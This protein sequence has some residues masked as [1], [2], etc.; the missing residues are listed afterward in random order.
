[1]FNFIETSFFLSLGITF[2]LILLLVYHFNQRISSIEQKS[3]T[4]FEIINNLVKEI[5]SLKQRVV[6]S[7]FA[8]FPSGIGVGGGGM[9]TCAAF[10][11]SS[12][13]VPLHN[14]EMM[15]D[16]TDIYNG[17]HE[18]VKYADDDVEDDDEDDDD[19]DDD[20]YHYYNNVGDMNEVKHIEYIDDFNDDDDIDDEDNGLQYNPEFEKTTHFISPVDV[21][22][23]DKMEVSDDENDED[24]IKVINI[25]ELGGN[26]T[27]NSEKMS[28]DVLDIQE[29]TDDVAPESEPAEIVVSKIDEPEHD[30]EATHE[31]AQSV[32]HASSKEAYKKMNLPA[33]KALVI[34]KGLISDPSK[35]KKHD[36]I[37][38]LENENA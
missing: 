34:S 37:Q 16:E 22:E 7:Q 27:I 14:V 20:E 9:G 32:V 15:T 17:E 24:E 4:M 36:L 21:N 38:L 8:M 1:M 33:L 23:I 12:E 26:F 30:T 13:K 5:N 35:M 25:P 6:A 18:D 19:Y 28:A 2:I 11:I 31:D 3:E 10:N 29:M